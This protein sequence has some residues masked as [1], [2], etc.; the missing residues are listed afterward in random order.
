MDYQNYGT[1]ELS[2]STLLL[3]TLF[4]WRWTLVAAILGAVIGCALVT[5]KSGMGSSSSS[6]QK[7]YQEK[8]SE[9]K[10]ES[11]YYKD[12]AKNL[13]QQIA[14]KQNYLRNSIRSHINPKKEGYASVNL[15]IQAVN[16]NNV[17]TAQASQAYASFL[18]NSV[19]WDTL[20]EEMGTE[21]EYLRELVTVVPDPES[22]QTF[23]FS[24]V[25]LKT[26]GRTESEA[27]KIL[28]YM[29]EQLPDARK[30]IGNV[31]PHTVSQTFEGSGCVVDSDLNNSLHTDLDLIKNLKDDLDTLQSNAS[32]VTRP[33]SQTSISATEL[34]KSAV[35]YA[36]AGFGVGAVLMYI[37]LALFLVIRHKVMSAEEM[38]GT[39]M[40][41]NLATY[42]SVKKKGL[43]LKLR[44]GI[45]VDA[46]T[47]EK[48]FRIAAVNLAAFLN[49]MEEVRNI[50][51]CGD[52]PEED[53]LRIAEKLEEALKS[54]H[55]LKELKIIP[56]EGIYR[57]PDALEKLGKSDGVIL[58]E[59]VEYS[60]YRKI[61]R[62]VIVINNCGKKIF[63]SLTL[64]S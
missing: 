27:K 19:N 15:I 1:K 2:F 4:R 34:L 17:S 52:L 39:F 18:K 62:D 47:E 33:A 3:R 41:K 12:Q 38:N 28:N 8:L 61:T 49:G 63:G 37:L 55:F 57:D 40:L 56:V 54:E 13:K 58:A 53:L 36:L 31:I 50:L 45:T 6:S 23:S 21:P 51:L 14:D 32:A 48:A 26:I 60:D 29:M 24:N 16:Q 10:E 43:D 9:Y 30:E 7:E 46:D 22:K 11:S 35:K 5:V 44:K 64:E 42:P 20:A 59:K 25:Y